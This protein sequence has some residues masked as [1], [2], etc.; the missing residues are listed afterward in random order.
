MS[1]RLGLRTACLLGAF[2]AIVFQ[3]W[4]QPETIPLRE[5]WALQSAAKETAGGEI[6]STAGNPV[7]GWYPTSVPRTVLAALVDNGVFPDPY[8]GTNLKSI[9]GYQDGGWLV[10]KEGSPFRD[11]WWYRV[12]FDMPRENAGRCVTLHFDGINYQA[13]VWLNGVRIADAEIMRGM[14][15]RFEFDVSSGLK[16]GARNALAV[17]IIPPGLIPDKDY[18]TKQI[19][20]TTGW[21]DHNPQPPDRNMGLWENVYLRIQGPVT[22]RNA[23]VESDLAVPALDSAKLTV[24]AY[25]HNRSGNAVKGVLKG[26]I[27][28]IA[29]S[30]E[31]TLQPGETREVVCAPD[32]YPQL[33]VRNPRVWWPHPV[34]PQELYNLDL[35]FL[36]DE[37]ASDAQRV[38]FGIR[39]IETYI[40]EEDWRGYRV[41]GRNILIRGGAW[42]TSEMLLRLS[43]PRYAA[44]VRYARE[45]NLNMLRSEGFSIRETETFYNLCDELGVM[46]TQQ[47]FG[48]SI[49]DEA[50]A[51]ACI[52]DMM[53]R[54]RTHPSLAHFLGHDETQPTPTLDKAYRDLITKYRVDR[55]YQPHSGTFVTTQ[56]KETGGTRTGT[57]ELWTYA[58]PSHY[59]FRKHDGAWGFAQSGGIGGVT[60]VRDSLRQ[61]MPEDQLWPAMQSESWSFHTVTQGAEYFEAIQKAMERGY[62]PPAG[63]D[64]FCNKAYAM[65]YNSAR[66]MM[67]AY[68]RNKYS[69]TGITAWKFDPAWPAATTWQ[70]VDWYLRPTAAYYGEQKACEPLHIQYAYDDESIYVINGLYEPF[71]GLEASATVYDFDLSVKYTNKATVN[72][73]ADGKAM[74]FKMAWPDHLSKTFFLRLVLRDAA[75]TLR[76]ENFYWL[77]T[78]PDVPGIAGHTLKGGFYTKPKSTADFTLLNSL[79]PTQV[80]TSSTRETRGEEERLTVTLRNTGTALAFLLQLAVTKGP[81]GREVGP[82]FWEE[83]YLSL[84]PG[85]SRSVTVSVPKAALESMEPAVRV[86]GWNLQ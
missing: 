85:E 10:M 20:A 73:E 63:F 36:V 70:C 66:G 59:Y 64:D 38:R 29:F 62:G 84:L 5:G 75:G 11:P 80:E 82:S 54:V 51:I 22:L 6:L 3:A 4:A 61:M 48:R 24:S 21:D 41:N 72:V 33:L 26:K 65:N 86:L 50:L 17:Q 9:P 28:D 40:N 14:F 16:Y 55:S 19:E 8:Y 34:G 45:A 30:Q 2:A 67:E 57:R 43:E 76:S 47:I 58:G 56:R 32:A 46:V 53:L 25:L 79:A 12:E 68:G 49:P 81:G 7:S 37:H 23:Y 1:K 69:A 18:D 15:R 31:L 71:A 60:A 27:E 13:N 44:L 78:A 35:E 77:S 39:K 83:N 74:A 42:M 52:D